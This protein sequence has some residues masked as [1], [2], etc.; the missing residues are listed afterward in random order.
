MRFKLAS[1][2]DNATPGGVAAP[3]RPARFAGAQRGN[4]AF[5]LVPVVL[6]GAS[7]AGA[8]IQ[9]TVCNSD[10]QRFGHMSRTDA[11]QVA[12]S[13]LSRLGGITPST[14]DTST[15]SAYSVRRQAVVREWSAVCATPDGEYLLRMNA[16]TQRVYAINRMDDGT[17]EDEN[18]GA[19][20]GSAPLSVFEPS[21]YRISH[22]EA[23]RRARDYVSVIGMSPGDLHVVNGRSHPESETASEFLEPEWNFTFQNHKARKTRHLVTISV[24]SSDG[25]LEHLWNP[26]YSL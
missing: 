13:V 7:C 11:C 20:D 4:L 14:C 8:A 18:A 3:N 19:S 24:R 15:Q 5:C 12:G 25:K 17:T 10:D 16:D 26:V 23:E 21:D 22:A 9:R 1:S 2:V 6:L